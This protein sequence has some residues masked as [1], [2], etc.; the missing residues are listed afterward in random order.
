MRKRERGVCQRRTA[1]PLRFPS[2]SAI[3]RGEKEKGASQATQ[4]PESVP[5]RQS[6]ATLRAPA[7]IL[8]NTKIAKGRE[9][10]EGLQDGIGPS[11]R[12]IF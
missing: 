1:K 6:S 11:V 5:F 12:R 7:G 8:F 2:F 9:G 3:K 4:L 10:H